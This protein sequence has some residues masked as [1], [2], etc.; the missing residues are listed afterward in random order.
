MPA[1]R[2]WEKYNMK[3]LDPNFFQRNTVPMSPQI[4]AFF[5]HVPTMA[6]IDRI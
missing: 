4:G 1:S 5:G 3:R 2:N 6:A